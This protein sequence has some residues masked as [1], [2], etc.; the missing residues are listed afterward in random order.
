[1][2]RRDCAERSAAEVRGDIWPADDDTFIYTHAK[3]E[4]GREGGETRTV[5]QRESFCFRRPGLAAAADATA[6]P[7]MARQCRRR[8]HA[9]CAQL[10]CTCADRCGVRLR[11]Q[12]ARSR[13]RGGKRRRRVGIRRRRWRGAGSLVS[14]GFESYWRAVHRRCVHGASVTARFGACRGGAGRRSGRRWRRPSWRC[15]WRSVV[16]RPASSVRASTRSGRSVAS[17][18]PSRSSAQCSRSARPPRWCAIHRAPISSI[19]LEFPPAT[20]VLVT[21]Y[22]MASWTGP[23]FCGLQAAGGGLQHGPAVRDVRRGGDLGQPRPLPQPRRAAAATLRTA[24]LPAGNQHS[25][26]PQ[27]LAV[28]VDTAAGVQG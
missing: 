2:A 5:V 21:K 13:P 7:R 14:V 11:P 10:K 3:R 16:G 4:G 24:R 22:S 15:T 6:Q 12:L 20:A 19:W 1:M 25:G 9:I 27:P 8:H 26:L 23:G 28:C 17:T 18:M